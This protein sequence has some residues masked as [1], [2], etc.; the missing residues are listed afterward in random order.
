MVRSAVS[1]PRV[2]A[3][4]V[5]SASPGVQPGRRRRR[6]RR[7]G[8]PSAPSTS[9]STSSAMS[10]PAATPGSPGHHRRGRRGVGGHRRQRGHVGPVAQ[11]LVERRARW[12][13][14]PRRARRRSSVISTPRR[15]RRPAAGGVEP[16]GACSPRWAGSVSGMVGAVVAAAGSRCG[17]APPPRRRAAV[18]GQRRVLEVAARPAMARGSRRAEQ[19]GQRA[20]SG[21]VA[22]HRGVPR[23][24]ALQLGAR[25]RTRRRIG[26]GDAR[27]GPAPTRRARRQ[28]RP[29]RPP[30]TRPSSRLLDASRLAPCM[31]VRATSPAANRPGQFGAPVRRR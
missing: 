21:A 11:V 25:Q 30:T 5:S 20:Q 28:P 14:A 4:S 24:R 8:S 13:R 1:S 16:D 2:G 29:A 23:H 18:D 26:V 7:P 12:P 31:P 6:G 22:H 19:V 15:G 3:S 27:P 9:S 10:T 17:P